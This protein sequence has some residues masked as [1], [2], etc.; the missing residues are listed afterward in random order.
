MQQR[1]R[2]LLVQLHRVERQIDGVA[3]G[4]GSFVVPGAKERQNWRSNWQSPS[5]GG[6]AL[7]GQR[8]AG[9]PREQSWQNWQNWRQSP[10][11]M[12]AL[13]SEPSASLQITVTEHGKTQQTLGPRHGS[14]NALCSATEHPQLRGQP[15]PRQPS[16]LLHSDRSRTSRFSL[17][18][19]LAGSKHR[20][21]HCL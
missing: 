1:P 3:L 13:R 4:V 21:L 6:I 7:G 9:I 20:T 12:G 15:Q 8:F 14:P 17:H 11:E 2:G 16:G 18:C 19:L 10:S 5:D